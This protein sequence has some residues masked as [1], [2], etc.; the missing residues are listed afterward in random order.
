MSKARKL[1]ILLAL[2]L[3]AEKLTFDQRVEIVRGMTA[4]YATVKT[5]LPR[6]KNPLE[7]KATGEYDKA[8]WEETGKKLGPAARVGDLVQITKVDIDDS[9]IVFE[10]N[11]GM[12]GGK[13][14]YERIEVGMGTS[15]RPISQNGQ[16]AAPG[17]TVLALLFDEKTPPLEAAEIKKLLAPILDFEKRTATEQLID[18]LPPEV[19][20]AVKEQRAIEGMDRDQ[21]L[22]ALGKPKSKI[23]ET[24]EG[25]DTEDWIYGQPPGKMTFVTFASGKVIRV[26]DTYAG[27]GG[28]TA[29]PLRPPL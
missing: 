5:Y 25:L 10:I 28:Q 13:K 15:T 12:K 18:T 3:V 24:K 29:P 20:Q 7:F 4:E 22:L 8:Q 2:P 11:G 26:K 16:T 23:R 1:A 6:S 21:V 27:L 19:A 17:G 14:W 9:R